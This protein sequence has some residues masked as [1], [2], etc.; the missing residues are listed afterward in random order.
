MAERG[1]EMSKMTPEEALEK[2]KSFIDEEDTESA[3]IH[4]DDLMCEI[5]RQ[6]GFSRVS[7]LFESTGKWYA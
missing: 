2:A 4:L 7:E 3:H 6:N 5:L 1:S